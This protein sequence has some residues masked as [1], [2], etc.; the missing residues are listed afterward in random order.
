MTQHDKIGPERGGYRCIATE[1]GFTIP[2][3]VEASQK[4]FAAEPERFASTIKATQTF[5]M[6]AHLAWREQLLDLGQGRIAQMDAHGVD[7][8]VLLLSYSG[9]QCFEPRQG[10]ELARLANDRLSEAMRRHPGRLAGLATAPPQ[11]PDAAAQEIER[12]VRDLG[13]KGALINSH[14]NGE[15]LDLPK[16]R[17]IFEVLNK[18]GVPLYLHPREPSPVLIEGYLPYGLEGPVWGYG[19]E[20]AIHALRL[21]FSGLFDDFPNLRIVIG[22][23]GE[24]IPPMLFRIDHRSAMEGQHT[25]GRRLRSKPSE[26]FKANFAVTSSGN[27]WPPLLEL[28]REVVGI[29]NLMFAID[30]PFEDNAQALAQVAEVSFT[31]ED[32]QKFFQTNA[33]RIFRL[34]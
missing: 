19:A 14:T 31:A 12:A 27:N 9:V 10:L 33:E 4:L 32:K 23:G 30:H 6:E 7:T 15:Y 8:Q 2:E 21:I 28:C 20:V 13:L 17:P 29:D 1:E 22:H 24:G 11:D 34:D 5:P 3:I 18:L 16:Y 25:R 26:Y